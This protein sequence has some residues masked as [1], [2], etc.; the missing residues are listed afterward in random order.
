MDTA[1]LIARLLLALVFVVAGV[2]KLSDRKGSRQ[3]ILDFGLPAALATPLGV[4]LPLAELAVAAALIPTATA[5]WGAIGAL[6][7]LLL[8]I[9]GIAA[10]LARGRKPD[11]HCFGQLHSAPA[12]WKTLLR[13]GV[14]AAVAGFVV[15]QGKEGSGPSAVSW[16]GDLSTTQLVVLIGGLV[17]LGVIAAQG[18]FLVHLL[19]QNGRLLVRLETL[20]E[21]LTAG[22]GGGAPLS[23]NGTPI[24]PAAGLPVGSQ[25]PA[26]NLSGLYGETLTLESLRARNKPVML[27]FTDPNCGPCTA[28]LPEIAR[29]QE[30]HAGKLIVSLISRGNIEENRAKITEHGLQNVLLQ[31]DWEVAQAYQAAGTP[32]AVLVNP[33]GTIGSPVVGGAEGIRTL[34]AQAVGER[35]QLPMQPPQLAQQGEP[36]PNCGK[37][38]AN[39]NGAQAAQQAMP[40]GAKVGETAPEIKLKDLEDKTINLK[41]FRGNKTLVL[42]WNPGC[43]FCEQMLDDLKEW[44]ANSPEE[45]PKLLVVSAGTK[46]ANKEMELQSP[47]V[48]DQNFAVGRSFGANGTPSAV[49]VDER[50]KVASEVAVGAQAVLELAGARQAEA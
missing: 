9:L 13:N 35:A 5:W 15:W 19:R 45:A 26:F 8:F 17:V 3:A 16:I 42:F 11:C 31:K 23:Q 6:A 14:L 47:V 37:V 34:L 7:L 12:G 40:A 10:N 38:H 46:E 18:W 27:L 49:L 41:G 4:L 44:E 24:Q 29:W 32:S 50:G 22:E 33:D 30:E 36:C 1:S 20:E 48:L 28:L 43:G 39:G 2:A 25:A 21:R